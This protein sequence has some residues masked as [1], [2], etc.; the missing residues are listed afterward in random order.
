[1]DIN[2]AMT[3][4]LSQVAQNARGERVLVWKSYQFVRNARKGSTEFKT[5]KM[6][7]NGI[8]RLVQSGEMLAHH[9]IMR[10]DALIVVCLIGIWVVSVSRNGSDDCN[11]K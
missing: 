5:R 7:K 10:R 9:V 11:E 1:L 8:A 6:A 4:K 3:K 2:I